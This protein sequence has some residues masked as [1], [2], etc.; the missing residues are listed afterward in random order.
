M[1]RPSPSPTHAVTRIT[2]SSAEGSTRSTG[3]RPSED[4]QSSIVHRRGAHVCVCVS[5]TYVG[6]PVL[7]LAN[8]KPLTRYNISFTESTTYAPPRSYTSIRFAYPMT[9]GPCWSN[10]LQ[11]KMDC[12]ASS[13][14]PEQDPAQSSQFGIIAS[15]H[16]R[17]TYLSAVGQSLSWLSLSK[18]ECTWRASGSFPRNRTPNIPGAGWG[19]K[20]TRNNCLKASAFMTPQSW[21]A[22]RVH[23]RPWPPRHTGSTGSGNRKS[24]NIPVKCV[25]K[26]NKL[27]LHRWGHQGGLG[28]I[29]PGI[30]PIL[31]GRER[32]YST[33]G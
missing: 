24:A 9:A 31:S 5:S 14:P 32:G 2:I 29:P 10:A 30:S 18:D 3:G 17:A 22:K 25:L 8:K 11:D 6:I 4:R 33:T 7:N 21:E 19:G 26:I 27:L 16:P 23:V 15:R 1:W 13:S 12:Y 28:W 20:V